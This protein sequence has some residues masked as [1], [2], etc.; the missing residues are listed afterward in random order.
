MGRPIGIS[1]AVLAL[2][3]CAA[4]GEPTAG[5]A[6]ESERASTVLPRRVVQVAPP[7]GN[8]GT[9]DESIRTALAAARAGDVIQFQAGVYRVVNGITYEVSTPGV[10]LRGPSTAGNPLTTFRGGSIGHE[11]F[12]SPTFRLTGEGQAVRHL[13]FLQVARGLELRE[14]GGPYRVERCRFRRAL[15]GVFV[16]GPLTDVLIRDNRFVNVGEPITLLST[17]SARVARNTM[18]APDPGTIPVFPRAQ[19]AVS[20]QCATDICAGNVIEDNL[21]SGHTEGV[22]IDPRFGAIVEDNVIRRNRFLGLRVFSEFETGSMVAQEPS[23]GF[24]RDNRVVDNVLRGSEGTGILLLDA[25]RTTIAGN[26]ISG[27]TGHPSL[28]QEL[29]GVGVFVGPASAQN[30]ILEN[31]FRENTG[32]DILLEGDRNRVVTRGETSVVD[33]GERNRID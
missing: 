32:P 10:E 31:V 17:S 1:L 23:G 33:N 29:S 21:V 13:D 14:S 12:Q 30:R 11:S 18:I 7:A 2:S 20:L 28:P 24:I 22:L 8:A 26:R 3:S 15:D 5:P 6:A 16:S 4:P 19:A 27:V 9:D 25:V